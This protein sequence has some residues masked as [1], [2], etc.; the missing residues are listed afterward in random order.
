M[1]GEEADGVLMSTNAKQVALGLA[2][3]LFLEGKGVVVVAAKWSDWD[4]VSLQVASRRD[5]DLAIETLGFTP[6][7]RYGSVGIVQISARGEFQGM[8]I[9]IHGPEE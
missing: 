5:F 8:T 9:K 6:G 7:K 4:G 2:T 1:A 3:M